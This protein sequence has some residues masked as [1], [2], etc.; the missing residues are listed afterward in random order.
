MLVKRKSQYG[1]KIHA[2]VGALTTSIITLRLTP[3]TIDA[4]PEYIASHAV[5]SPLRDRLCLGL[6]NP[7]AGR[8]DLRDVIYRRFFFD[9]S[10][11]HFSKCLCEPLN[12]LSIN[13]WMYSSTLAY[14][15]DTNTGRSSTAVATN[16]AYR[17][18]LAFIAVEIAIPLQVSSFC[19]GRA[20]SIERSHRIAL[21]M[22]DCTLSGLAC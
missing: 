5:A 4:S 12:S 1:G 20:M 6:P 14:I 8:C 9:V 17:G 22:V 18:I 16:S 21:E 19:C 11:P 3:E 2:E 7:P 13:R 10:L 15:V